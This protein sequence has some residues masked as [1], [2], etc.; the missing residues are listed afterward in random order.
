T[1]QGGTTV[2]APTLTT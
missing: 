1:V 2:V